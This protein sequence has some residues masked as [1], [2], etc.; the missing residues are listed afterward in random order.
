MA[1][2]VLNPDL[3]TKPPKTAIPGAR[4]VYRSMAV[5]AAQL[6]TTNIFAIG[7]LPAGHRLSDLKLELSRIDSQTSPDLT[8]NVGILNCYY[9][10]SPN[11]NISSPALNS[12]LLISAAALVSPALWA[13]PGTT[14]TLGIS[15]SPDPVNDQIIAAQTVTS[16]GVAAAGTIAIS[17]TIDID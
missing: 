8:I 3:Y 10:T 13:Q 4:K 11:P 5:T 6:L 9:N 15:Q 2:I 16:P 12:P 14:L 1:A 17:Y 7:V